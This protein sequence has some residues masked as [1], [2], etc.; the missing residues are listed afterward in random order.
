M[1]VIL[2]AA[3]ADFPDYKISSEGVL[4]SVKFGKTRVIKPRKHVRGYAEYKLLKN[5]K[6]KFITAHRLVA[7]AFKRKPYGYDQINH[8]NGNKQ[9]NSIENLEWTTAK[10]NMRHAVDDLGIRFGTTKLRAEQVLEIRKLHKTGLTQRE[11]ADQFDVSVPT[12]S[13][14]VNR[15]HW[16][17]I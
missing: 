10:L 5:G 13:G 15:K 12:I 16:V 14:I 11:L 17:H 8:L 4:V 2:W 3:V 7:T 6:A 9:D 1:R